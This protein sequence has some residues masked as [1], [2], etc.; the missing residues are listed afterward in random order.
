MVL[1]LA[2]MAPIMRLTFDSSLVNY[3][4]VF[5]LRRSL[6]LDFQIDG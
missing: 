4:V 6:L 5:A 2:A 1:A 3:R